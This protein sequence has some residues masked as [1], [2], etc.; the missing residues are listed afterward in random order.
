[1]ACKHVPGMATT[2]VL[3]TA[4][5]Q[6]HCRDRACLNHDTLLS[7]HTRFLVH[8][9][10]TQQLHLCFRD[11]QE[12]GQFYQTASSFL[13]LAPTPHPLILLVLRTFFILF[14]FHWL[15]FPVSLRPF[16]M[17]PISTHH[18]FSPY[19]VDIRLPLPLPVSSTVFGFESMCRVFICCS[20]HS[21][22]AK[23]S[24][25]ILGTA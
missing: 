11:I 9:S 22:F 21:P 10:A 5:R 1:M 4:A 13:S 18:S 14:F 15:F 16:V 6:K 23:F 12:W 8:L 20:P 2:A 19:L 24:S 17:C 25:S 7:P 3:G